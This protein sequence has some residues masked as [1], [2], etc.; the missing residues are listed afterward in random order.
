[1]MDWF[2]AR[3]QVNAL[4]QKWMWETDSVQP[5]DVPRMIESIKLELIHRRAIQPGSAIVAEIIEEFRFIKAVYKAYP[6]IGA[7]KDGH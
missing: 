4:W 7:S 1:M 2:R 5:L 3:K 6:N